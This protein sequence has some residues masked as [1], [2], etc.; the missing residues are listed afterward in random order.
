V[1]SLSAAL[2]V[3]FG[4]NIGTTTTGWMVALAGLKFNFASIALPVIALGVGAQVIRKNRPTGYFGEGL[5]GI[6]L[7]FYGIMM[8]QSGFNGLSEG[9]ELPYSEGWAGA[10]VQLVIGVVM[11][12]IMQSSSAS[13]VI[14][15]SAA[16]AGMIDTSGAAALVIGANVGTTVTAV[17]AMIGGTPNAKRVASAHVFLRVVAAVVGFLLLP[18]L[19]W[20]I[21]ILG[22]WFGFEESVA[23]TLALFNTMFN[24]FAVLLLWP[25]VNVL[26]KR[27][28]KWFVPAEDEAAAKP[29]YLDQ[30]TL[31]VPSLAASALAMEVARIVSM[32]W[33]YVACTINSDS[34]TSGRRRD[35]YSLLRS[36]QEFVDEMS[37]STMD[38]VTSDRLTSLLRVLRYLEN[39]VE[40]VYET[41]RLPL[42]LLKS[43]MLKERYD[44]Y[45]SALDTLMQKY[46]DPGL[47]RS[48]ENNR[49]LMAGFEQAYQDLK[50]TLLR[51]GAVG[52]WRVEDMELALQRIS[53]QRRAVKQMVKAERWLRTAE[54][55][56]PVSSEETDQAG[57]Q[58]GS[59]DDGEDQG[60]TAAPTAHS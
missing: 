10:F 14:A 34:N 7:L 1:L 41:L 31:P 13:T 59:N 16:Q 15:I 56:S 4:A 9:W 52:H 25:F 26:T 3:L 30:T 20:I 22:H 39:V 38:E 19:M 47:G 60:Q 21:H 23:T 32:A 27:L 44:A 45:V 48:K 12:V 18:V 43:D 37:R 46:H 54:R 49:K 17:L 6:G 40:L 58:N 53:S 57:E 36:S 50:S 55:A 8:M 33:S 2:F 29:I 42:G 28:G 24:I 35:L 51:G 11:T 5:A